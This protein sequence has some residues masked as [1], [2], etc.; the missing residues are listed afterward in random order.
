MKNKNVLCILLL[1]TSV[2]VM[3]NTDNEVFLEQSGDTLTLEI[4]Q[5]GYGNKICGSVNGGACDSDWVL[6]GD[7]LNINLDILGNDNQ[8]FGNTIFNNSSVDITISGD[9]NVW[10]W[11]VGYIGSVDSTDILVDVTGDTNTFDID[12]GYDAST[13]RL[14]FD[15]DVLGSLNSLDVDID[16]D[17]AIWDV[18]ITG[19][20]NT[21]TSAVSDGNYHELNFELSGDNSQ[22]TLIQDSGTC[23]DGIM[24]CSGKIDVSLDGDNAM[25]D[26]TQSDS[27]GG[28]DLAEAIDLDTDGLGNP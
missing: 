12:L 5:I 6:T 10:D 20:N 14:D 16:A 21:F 9:S 23:P 4:D 3:A 22:V 27:L 18:D 7:Q 11:D 19:N 24:S 17:D 26:I 1:L 2:S 15:L 25:V 8:I 28:L 13:E